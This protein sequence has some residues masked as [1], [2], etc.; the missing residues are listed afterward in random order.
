MRREDV[1]VA[2]ADLTNTDVPGKI[3][4]QGV[5]SNVSVALAYSTAWL[6]GNGCIPVN[7]LMEDAATAE[8]ARVQLWQWVKYAV[9]MDNGV[10]ITVAFVDH[11]IDELAPT[12]K[13][14]APGINEKHLKITTDY[15]KGQIRQQ[16]P[17]DFLTS[18][19]MPFLTMA[20]GVELKWQHSSL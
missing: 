14:V 1:V 15:L 9:R 10:S 6:G 4:E 7:H 19:L 2:A 20:D 17:S 16:W 3:T 5:R 13:S 12:I 11:I 18:D 8:I